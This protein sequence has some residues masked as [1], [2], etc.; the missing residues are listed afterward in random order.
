MQLF[1]PSGK[2]ICAVAQRPFAV[3]V[4]VQASASLAHYSSLATWTH[5]TIPCIVC[6]GVI[7]CVWMILQMYTRNLMM[8][9]YTLQHQAQ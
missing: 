5:Q 7:T 6:R 1:C 2:R 9:R 3:L 8:T 4:L